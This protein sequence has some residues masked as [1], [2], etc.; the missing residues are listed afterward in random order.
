M[1]R[2]EHKKV[3]QQLSEAY[4][5]VINERTRPLLRS[6]DPHGSGEPDYDP[7]QA[8]REANPNWGEPEQYG[9]YMGEDEDAEG[10]RFRL[11]GVGGQH[12][13]IENVEGE[14]DTIDEL[15]NY[16]GPKFD[17]SNEDEWDWMEEIKDP[18]YWSSEGFEDGL[19]RF[20]IGEIYEV[21]DTQSAEDDEY[22][23][24]RKDNIDY[25]KSKRY[26]SEEPDPLDDHSSVEAYRAAR[27]IP[28]P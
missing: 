2:N 3:L 9:G 6:I 25:A 7:H 4:Q 15:I 26:E 14:F 12:S 23:Q 17:A 13:Q 24:E 16:L 8:A 21:V 20:G 19:L 11:V 10:K 1:A 22:D 27:G 28:M 18:Q 5:K